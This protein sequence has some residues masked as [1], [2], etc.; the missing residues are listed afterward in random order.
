M[1][2]QQPGSGQGSSALRT[3]LES[4]ASQQPGSGSVLSPPPPALPSNRPALRASS[5]QP[6]SVSGSSAESQPSLSQDQ[7]GNRSALILSPGESPNNDSPDPVVDPVTDALA[8]AIYHLMEQPWQKVL[9]HCRRNGSRMKVTLKLV[10]ESG[11]EQEVLV[12]YDQPVMAV[13]D[14]YCEKIGETNLANTQLVFDGWNVLLGETPESMG[15]EDGDMVEV[16]T[17]SGQAVRS[18]VVR[19]AIA[20]A[21]RATAALYPHLSALENHNQRN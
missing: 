19:Q 1:S 8:A 2:P 11:V 14:E 4:L 9:D 10:S 5:G 7:N 3:A 20:D 6:S 18:E 16:M 13:L 17:S 12:P 21:L 15:M